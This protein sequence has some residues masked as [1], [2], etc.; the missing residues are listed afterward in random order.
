[1]RNML[2]TAQSGGLGALL[3][4]LTTARAATAGMAACASP[5]QTR[6]AHASRHGIATCQV[7]SI[8]RSELRP[9]AIM[10]SAAT[11]L[12][13]ALIQPTARGEKPNC[14]II[15]GDHSPTAYNPADDPE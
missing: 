10:P 12:G 6:P 4:K 7:R 15:S 9:Q 1:E 5:A 3:P 2:G 14:L 11:M 8:M 13:I